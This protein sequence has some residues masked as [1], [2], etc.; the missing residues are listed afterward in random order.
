MTAPRT[1]EGF[2]FVDDVETDVTIEF[3]VWGSHSPATYWD[4]EEFPEIEV[5][6][7]TSDAGDDVTD[8]SRDQALALVEL[9]CAD[10]LNE[11]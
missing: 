8:D 6:A 7:V 10:G 4:P 3:F 9:Y 2:V 11:C 5:T 1:L